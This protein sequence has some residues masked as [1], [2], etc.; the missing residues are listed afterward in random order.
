MRGQGNVVG[1]ILRIA[2]EVRV[3]LDRPL[4]KCVMMVLC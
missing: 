2:V 4:R 1:N 3:E